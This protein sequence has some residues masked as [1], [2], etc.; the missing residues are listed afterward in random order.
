MIQQLNL[1]LKC[2]KDD[3]QDEIDIVCYN[4]FCTEF[5]LN[6]FQCQ[7]KGRTHHDH[8][9]DVEKINSLIEFIENKNKECDNL[10]DDLNKQAESMNQSFSQLKMGIRQKYQLYQ[11]RLVLLNSQ[12]INDFLNST[13]KFNEYKQSITTII[14][15]QTKK[16]THSFNNLYQQLQLSSFNYY[17]NDDNCYQLY[18]E[19][20]YEQ[21]IVILDKSIQYNPNNYNSL[22]CKGDCLKLLNQYEEGISWLDQSLAIDPKN[23]DTLFMK[24]DCLRLLNK[25]EEAIKWLDKALTIDSKHVDSL[26]IKGQCLRL[27]NK[28]EEAIKWLDKALAINP[29]HVNSLF[30]IGECLR[31]LKKYNESLQF[32]DQALSIDQQHTL[33]LQAK[34][35]CLMDQ[36]KYQEA[37]IYYE[38]SLKIDP[39]DQN[40]KNQKNFCEKKLKQ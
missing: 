33:S 12:Q 1:K 11:E 36:Q 21:A 3:H 19:D 20:K 38:K 28:N 23:A 32:L 25:N 16:L 40:T 10:I 13:I 14:L 8:F 29:K 6:C 22:W 24:G 5:R 7:K 39:Y 37:L 26:C 2:Q 34:G 35:D 15:E 4:Q 18:L 9:D 27:L 17:Q 31:L 30:M